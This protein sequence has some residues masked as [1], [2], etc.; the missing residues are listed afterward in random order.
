MFVKIYD[1]SNEIYINL[2]FF[3]FLYVKLK[4]NFRYNVAA[5]EKTEH[6][7]CEEKQTMDRE[8]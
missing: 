7:D 5:F 8:M 6:S 4:D 2:I 3:S 1:I